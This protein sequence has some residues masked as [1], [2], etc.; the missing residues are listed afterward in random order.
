M[1]GTNCTLLNATWWNATANS[2]G[3][4]GQCA[5]NYLRN[6]HCPEGLIDS[7]GFSVLLTGQPA[8]GIT[9]ASC[10]DYCSANVIRVVRI[11]CPVLFTH[12]DL[13]APGFQLPNLCAR[14]Y[15]LFSALDR[16]VR[17]TSLRDRRQL[18]QRHELL[19][20]CW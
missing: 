3:F 14:C 18:Q 6:A 4:A 10:L 17:T 2:R 19:P 5:T 8:S 20:W 7:N 9:Y 13:F 12:S 11:T 15:Q 1:D 16:T